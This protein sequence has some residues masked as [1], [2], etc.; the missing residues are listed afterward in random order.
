[1]FLEIQKIFDTVNHHYLM[2]K[3]RQMG[4]SDIIMPILKISY[5]N[6]SGF[7]VINGCKLKK[8]PFV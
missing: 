3:L 6:I 5:E 2:F 4:I 8:K 1:M 7:T